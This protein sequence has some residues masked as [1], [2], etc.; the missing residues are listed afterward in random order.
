[1]RSRRQ[2]YQLE[3]DAAEA[4]I[5]ADEEELNR[6]MEAGE[7]MN[8]AMHVGLPEPAEEPAEPTPP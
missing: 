1:M 6:V 8:R 5:Q 4:R 3:A 7:R 2:Q